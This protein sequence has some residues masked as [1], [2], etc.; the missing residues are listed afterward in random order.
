VFIKQSPGFNLVEKTNPVVEGEGT[1][2]QQQET[3]TDENG[4]FWVILVF[5]IFSL[6]GQVTV[7]GAGEQEKNTAS[8][9]GGTSKDVADNEGEDGEQ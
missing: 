3:V 1:S 4:I 6:G 8:S 5:R 9:D 7:T 2:A